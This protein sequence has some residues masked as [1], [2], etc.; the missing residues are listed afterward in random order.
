[1]I[2]W[3]EEVSGNSNGPIIPEGDGRD[4]CGVGRVC[5]PRTAYL[6]PEKRH[7]TANIPA[8]PKT[9][10]YQKR[11]KENRCRPDGTKKTGSPT[12]EKIG[13]GGMLGGCGWGGG[14]GST[15]WA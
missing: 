1:M 11:G 12:R 10:P 13:E 7:A 8:A 6:S 15:G 4:R 2:G 14:S 9:P 3:E 5:G